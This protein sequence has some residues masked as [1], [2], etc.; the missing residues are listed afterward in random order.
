[1]RPDL[2]AAACEVD[3]VG[4]AGGGVQDQGENVQRVGA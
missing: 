3:G 2:R 1:M 4:D